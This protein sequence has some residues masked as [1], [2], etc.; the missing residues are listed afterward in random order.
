MAFAGKAAADVTADGMRVSATEQVMMP[1]MPRAMPE[2]WGR[3]GTISS[4]L[5]QASLPGEGRNRV[6]I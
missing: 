2:G 6:M 1:R 3:E 4:L 5:A